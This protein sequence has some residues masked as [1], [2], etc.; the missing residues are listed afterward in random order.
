MAARVSHPALGALNTPLWGYGFRPCLLRHRA[1]LASR[2]TRLKALLFM[3]QQPL[4]KCRR[5]TLMTATA[6]RLTSTMTSTL[7]TIPFPGPNTEAGPG[8]R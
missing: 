4:P 1:M 5:L 2:S 8:P 3:A 6:P 7:P